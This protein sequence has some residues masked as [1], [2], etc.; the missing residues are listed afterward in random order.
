MIIDFITDV[1]NLLTRLI[2][3]KEFILEFQLWFSD[4]DFLNHYR[5]DSYVFPQFLFLMDRHHNLWISLS[6]G[7]NALNQ[8]PFMVA[9]K[10]VMV[11]SVSIR[12]GSFIRLWK[13]C[14]SEQKQPPELFYK[15]RY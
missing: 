14:V 3:T 12:A 9:R 7:D 4:K 2:T 1:N 6:D 15:K 8:N 13:D 10:R 11:T 5:K